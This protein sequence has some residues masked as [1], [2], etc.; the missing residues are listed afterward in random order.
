[1]C[2]GTKCVHLKL[3]GC[4]NIV[5]KNENSTSESQGVSIMKVAEQMK[6]SVTI[7]SPLHYCDR[8]THSE[9]ELEISLK[10]QSCVV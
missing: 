9:R 3:F 2:F 6:A 4:V 10:Y 8:L 5:L 1:M 7:L